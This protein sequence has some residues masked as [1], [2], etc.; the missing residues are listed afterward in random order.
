MSEKNP[1]LESAVDP[2]ES[3]L[4]SW[5]V[6][7]VGNKESPENGEVTVA[8]I[9]NVMAEEFPEFLM[10]IAEENWIRGYHQALNDV[11]EGERLAAEQKQEQ[12]N[13]VSTE[14]TE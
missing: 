8:N 9:V 7:Y 1:V 6:D 12:L 11:E 4:K 5:L 2:T 14:I 10:V 3:E 13:Q